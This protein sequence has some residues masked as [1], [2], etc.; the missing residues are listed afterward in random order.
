MPNVTISLNEKLLKKSR[1][2]ARKKN[3]SLNAMIRKLL[4]QT[5]E[6]PSGQWIDECFSNM[7]KAKGN[8]KGKKW[9]REELYD[10]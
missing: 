8:S 5:V 4:E 9:K 7:D 3:T 2:Y 6:S 10:I 1:E